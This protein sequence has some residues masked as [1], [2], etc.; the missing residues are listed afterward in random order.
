MSKDLLAE[1]YQ[2]KKA[3]AAKKGREMYQNL[4]Q[5]RSR[6][7]IENDIKYVPEHEKQVG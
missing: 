2:K 7:M 3:K 5:Q 4:F 1:Y 6:N